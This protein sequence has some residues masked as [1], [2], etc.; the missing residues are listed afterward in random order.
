MTVAMVTMVVVGGCVVVVFVSVA[1]CGNGEWRM[2]VA[3]A[4]AMAML[5]ANTSVA[6]IDLN[7]CVCV[8]ELQRSYCHT[9]RA[10]RPHNAPSL[11][12]EIKLLPIKCRRAHYVDVLHAA[13]NVFLHSE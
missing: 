6:S 13:M 7:I 10:T 8:C 11:C 9:S 3:M 12:G 1:A 5:V 2:A 4:M